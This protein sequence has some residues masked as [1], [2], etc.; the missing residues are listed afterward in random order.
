MHIHILTRREL[1]LKYFRLR[2]C[3][4]ECAGVRV[5]VRDERI[6]LLQQTV[7]HAVRAGNRHRIRFLAARMMNGRT[8]GRPRVFNTARFMCA[9]PRACRESSVVLFPRGTCDG[10]L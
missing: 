7:G 4:C 3:V 5:W 10:S 6:G 2:P 9:G 1:V 8:G